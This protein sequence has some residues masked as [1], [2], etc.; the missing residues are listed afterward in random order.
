MA[1]MRIKSGETKPNQ[2]GRNEATAL[3]RERENDTDA[4]G[5]D[6]RV[7]GRSAKVRLVLCDEVSV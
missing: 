2:S 5:E 1:A 7:D 3:S 4:E 6:Q